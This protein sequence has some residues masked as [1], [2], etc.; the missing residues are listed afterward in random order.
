MENQ[1]E[2]KPKSK[3]EVLPRKIVGGL[4]AMFLIAQA[5][6][7]LKDIPIWQF[8]L[9][10]GCMT[11]IGCMAVWTHYLLERGPKDKTVKPNV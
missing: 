4:F 10:I 1:T 7:E 9:T 8:V 11:F 6:K 3:W 5:A 2:I